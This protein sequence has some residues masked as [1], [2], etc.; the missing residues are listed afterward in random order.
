MLDLNT[1]TNPNR[2]MYMHQQQ[3]R[4]MAKQAQ[5]RGKE[6]QNTSRSFGEFFNNLRGSGN[7]LPDY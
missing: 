6:S 4:M 7:G 3:L 5:Q 1:I 2:R